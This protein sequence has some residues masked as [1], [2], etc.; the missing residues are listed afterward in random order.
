MATRPPRKPYKTD[1]TDAQWALLGPLIPPAKHGGRPRKV[2]MREVVNT[3]FYQART[4]VP[5]DYLPHDLVAKSTAWGR[6]SRAHVASL[7]RGVCACSRK[8]VGVRAG[9]R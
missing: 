5:W 4:G 3:L 7:H 9:E 8:R 2:D 6:R 1:V